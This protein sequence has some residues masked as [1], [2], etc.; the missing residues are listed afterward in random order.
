MV[1]PTAIGHINIVW[2]S[3]QESGEIVPWI[4]WVVNNDVT[5]LANW[6]YLADSRQPS[7]G[8]AELPQQYRSSRIGFC[9]TQLT[10]SFIAKIDEDIRKKIRNL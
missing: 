3:A 2:V 7:R 4:E 8:R 5:N 6:N 9:P 1:L 10:G